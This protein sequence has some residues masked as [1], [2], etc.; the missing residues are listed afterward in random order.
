MNLFQRNEPRQG[1]MVVSANLGVSGYPPAA[2]NPTV[3]PQKSPR[4]VVVNIDTRSEGAHA[5]EA[6]APRGALASSRAV[7][8]PVRG[9]RLAMVKRLS[10]LVILCIIGAT[11]VWAIVTA[12]NAIPRPRT[13]DGIQP[14][15]LDWADLRGRV[16]LGGRATTSV[17]PEREAN[18]LKWPMVI[19]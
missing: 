3:M 13:Q 7:I 10:V 8:V 9:S 1:L 5:S 18:S 12:L 14:T 6:P 19:D 2:L 11:V 17:R 16:L 15:S 4:S